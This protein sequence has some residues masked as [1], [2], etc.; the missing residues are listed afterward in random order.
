[1]A[2]TLDPGGPASPAA[3]QCGGCG[4]EI[5]AGLLVCPGCHRLVHSA[6]LNQ[7]KLDAESAAAAGDYGAEL[8]AWRSAAVLLPDGS[9][10]AIA[11]AA[12]IDALTRTGTAA[13]T[14]AEMPKTGLWKWVG[15]LGPVGL[16]IWKLKFLIIAVATKGKLLL[17]GLTKA[18]TVFSMLLAFG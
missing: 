15:G 17:L 14:P 8:A 11:V 9:R 3:I 4:S 18:S 12:K 5:A 6:A 2:T 16:L 1:M 10:Q 7:L 13:G